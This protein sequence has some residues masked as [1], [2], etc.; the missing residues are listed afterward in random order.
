LETS[1]R[2]Q[3]MTVGENAY[4]VFFHGCK[5]PPRYPPCNLKLADAVC[6]NIGKK[7]EKIR[8]CG[9]G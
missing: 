7:T 9:L 8:T 1:L 3:R 2:A 5:P 6:I 4:L